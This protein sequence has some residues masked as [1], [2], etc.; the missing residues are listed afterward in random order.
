MRP[1]KIFALYSLFVLLLA[2]CDSTSGPAE[3]PSTS[4]ES[5]SLT[6][7][8]QGS[9]SYG[10][11]L[12]FDTAVD[13]NMDQRNSMALGNEVN[14]D[15]V[16]AFIATGTG[17]N[18]PGVYKL[19]TPRLAI[20]MGITS[21][22]GM[23]STRLAATRMVLVPRSSLEHASQE[24]AQALYDQGFK[25]DSVTFSDSGSFGGSTSNAVLVKTTAG[26]LVQL[27]GTTFIGGA[28]VDAY[29]SLSGKRGSIPD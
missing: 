12:N 3:E 26:R 22:S 25:R 15:L 13:A 14:L 27:T 9:G 5:F 16:T 24:S 29:Y 1:H 28:D 18:P 2:G 8:A 20:R 4:W 17:P 21:T 23:D 10:P 7:G 6:S 11:L 19:L